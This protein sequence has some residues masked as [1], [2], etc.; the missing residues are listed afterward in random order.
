M[1]HAIEVKPSCSHAP[2]RQRGARDGSDATDTASGA[3]DHSDINGDKSLAD[4]VREA[5]IV[6]PEKH[7][8]VGVDSDGSAYSDGSASYASDFESLDD[9]EKCSE[10]G[11]R[12][13]C[14]GEG[15]ILGTNCSGNS[16]TGSSGRSDGIYHRGMASES[17]NSEMLVRARQ[18]LRS[19]NAG[20]S[21]LPHGCANGSLG[22]ASLITRDDVEVLGSGG[23][24][25]RDSPALKSSSDE[26]ENIQRL[27][28]NALVDGAGS[29]VSSARKN[30][31][32]STHEETLRRQTRA[33]QPENEP[34]SDHS[35]KPDLPC[36]LEMPPPPFAAVAVP[37]PPL[38]SSPTPL[39]P[40][41]PPRRQAPDP[42][43]HRDTPGKYSSS[44][45]EAFEVQSVM[46]TSFAAAEECEEASGA[47]RRQRRIRSRWRAEEAQASLAERLWTRNDDSMSGKGANSD[48]GDDSGDEICGT[49]DFAAPLSET[50]WALHS[51]TPLL[52]VSLDGVS[53]DEESATSDGGD[54][55]WEE[56]I[57]FNVGSL[58]ALMIN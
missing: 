49:V 50:E 20:E 57:E 52:E 24:I 29:T 37:M 23:P 46:N 1:K 42:P 19:N 54:V 55:V 51:Q 33:L 30:P 36:P 31:L 21:R 4:D 45:A 15:S 8:E 12:F 34:Q 27:P 28:G 26:L 7:V 40:H 48:S 32:I 58:E 39:T 6:S 44:R 17:M 2:P 16:S 9:N 22:L 38:S 53:S 43:Q 11:E 3:S 47:K 13:G 25:L 41:S 56:D 5:V 10:T 18:M 14:S 35:L